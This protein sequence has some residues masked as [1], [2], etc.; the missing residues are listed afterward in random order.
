LKPILTVLGIYKGWF[1]DFVR[2]WNKWGYLLH[3]LSSFDHAEMDTD[4]FGELR[5]EVR[6]YE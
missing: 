5:I 1:L 3:L 2:R 6:G 4:N